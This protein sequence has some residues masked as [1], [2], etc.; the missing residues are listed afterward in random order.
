M[1]SNIIDCEIHPGMTID[2]A[3]KKAIDM[4]HDSGKDVRII[5]NGVKLIIDKWLCQKEDL[6]R[7][8]WKKIIH[9]Q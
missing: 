6:V 5:F 3:V 8:Y 9:A 1:E 7:I 4:H 2:D